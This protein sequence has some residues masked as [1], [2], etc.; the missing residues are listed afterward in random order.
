MKTWQSN[1]KWQVLHFSCSTLEIRYLILI[2][3]IIFITSIKEANTCHLPDFWEWFNFSFPSAVVILLW[4]GANAMSLNIGVYFIFPGGCAWR[5]LLGAGAEIN[6]HC[7]S[8]SGRQQPL[9]PT[10]PVH[11]K[12]FPL[13]WVGGSCPVASTSQGQCAH[14]QPGC[15]RW[16]RHILH[17]D[18]QNCAMGI[19]FPP[20]SSAIPQL[21]FGQVIHLLHFPPLFAGVIYMARDE[22]LFLT[23][24][25]QR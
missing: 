19:C 23:R 18:V 22:L 25:E 24:A 9:N 16:W 3:V 20:G 5:S 6:P 11:L 13:G 10:G 17:Q 21:D 12:T 8:R 15:W 4:V 1:L 2:E 14:L 7:W